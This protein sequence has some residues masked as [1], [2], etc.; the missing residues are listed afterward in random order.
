VGGRLRVDVPEREA[1]LVV[2]H[3]VGRDVA[4]DDLA[5]QA[6]GVRHGRVL[7]RP[8]TVPDQRR[9]WSRSRLTSVT[10]VNLTDDEG[11]D[12]V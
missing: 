8:G 4:G 7:S 11:V 12:S 10:V 9:D 2:E 3:H 1:G 5:E 6:V